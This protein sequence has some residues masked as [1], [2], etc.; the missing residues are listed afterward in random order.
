MSQTET[1]LL[2]LALQAKDL[3][4]VIT[5]NLEAGYFM[6]TKNR[7]IFT[8]LRAIKKPDH[9]LLIDELK[10]TNKLKQAGDT[11][12]ITALKFQ[13]AESANVDDYMRVLRDEYRHRNYL[14][15][16]RELTRAAEKNTGSIDE[17]L[18]EHEAMLLKHTRSTSGFEE[19]RQKERTEEAFAYVNDAYARGG[20]LIGVNTGFSSMND[21]SGGLIPGTFNLILGVPGA[22][23]TALWL[24][25]LT[26][27][28]ASHHSVAMVQLEMTDAQLGLR[29]IACRSSVGMDRIQRGQLSDVDMNRI[30]DAAN[31]LTN[32]K[33]DV[34]NL[35]ARFSHWNDIERWFRRKHADEGCES[36]WI[37]NLKLVDGVGADEKERFQYVSRRCKL[38]ARELGVSVVAIHHVTKTMVGKPITVN[39]AYGSSAFRQDAD[40]ILLMNKDSEDEGA[41]WI[42]AGKNRNGVEGAKRKV[43]FNGALQRFEAISAHRPPDSAYDLEVF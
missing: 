34:I 25:L 20:S 23:K 21:V 3:Y 37:D 9:N 14:A 17:M 15:A 29:Q 24:Q 41:V 27:V 13:Q 28:A 7:T 42:E 6:D 38:L 26:H 2:A 33:Y 11:A 12:Y 40:F 35:D 10:R 30:V 43:F 19:T 1:A 16:L 22:G 32:L 4:P 36:L 31:D 8:A 39:D 5:E 18:A